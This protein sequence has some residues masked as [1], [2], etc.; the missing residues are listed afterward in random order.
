MVTVYHMLECH[1]MD[2][3]PFPSYSPEKDL[4]DDQVHSHRKNLHVGPEASWCLFSIEV[5]NT[6]GLPFD[7]SFERVQDGQY[8]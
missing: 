6:Y 5:R 4:P 1:G 8:H 7:V 2:I 3:L